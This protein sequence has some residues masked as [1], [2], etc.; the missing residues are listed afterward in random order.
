M[1]RKI[2]A[3]HGRG[4]RKERESKIAILGPPMESAHVPRPDVAESK[5]VVAEGVRGPLSV[6]QDEGGRS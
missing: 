3:R 1:G 5:T 6:S 2:D 4:E